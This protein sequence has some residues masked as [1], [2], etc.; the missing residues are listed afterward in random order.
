MEVPLVWWTSMAVLAGGWRDE[1]G[2]VLLVV[3]PPFWAR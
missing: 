2:V 3:L 1:R